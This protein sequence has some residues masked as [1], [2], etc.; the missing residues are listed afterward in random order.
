MIEIEVLLTEQKLTEEF[1]LALD[2]HYLAEKFFYWF[3]LSVKSWLDL[4]RKENPYK[5]YSRSHALVSKHA[6]EI[7]ARVNGSS[8]EVVGLGAGQGDKDLLVLEALKARGCESHYRPVDSSQSLLEMAVAR[9]KAAGFRTRGLKADVEN[10]STYD[11]LASSA[12]GPRL[13]LL[14]GN[15][16]GMI[17]PLEHL[18]SLRKLLRPEDRLLLDGEIYSP[19]ITMKGYDQPANRRFAFAPLASLGLEEGRDGALV[20]EADTDSRLEGLH[21]VTKHFRAAR[22]LRIPVAGNWAEVR[23]GDKIAMSSSWKY[24]PAVFHSIVREAGDCEFLAEYPSDDGGFLMALVRR[25]AGSR[26]NSPP[27]D[28]R[29][30]ERKM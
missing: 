27:P 10:P 2:Q 26:R 5:N 11:A 22:D 15:S 16:L 28:R 1:L 25:A 9:S 20:F 13:Y 12:D 3:P 7:A 8:V 23:G 14:L 6:A 18:Q 4:C 17:D 30:K 19:E 29:G 24:S 21:R